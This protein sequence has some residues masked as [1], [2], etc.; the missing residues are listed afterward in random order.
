MAK[1]AGLETARGVKVNRAMQSSDP[2]IFAV[3]D[4]AEP[5]GLAM[6]G[7]WPFAANQAEVAV[8]VLL[9]GEV[10]LEA[11]ATLMRLKSEGI[12]VLSFGDLSKKSGDS[13]WTSQASGDD[14]WSV[15]LQQGKPKA[16]VFVGPP[17][18]GRVFAKLVQA[19]GSE[20][21]LHELMQSGLQA[22]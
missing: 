7:L 14:W 12:D 17:G 5:E 11:A 1:A 19:E 20:A 3:G 22:N 13:R 18:N 15:T 8:A 2:N 10:K 4:V 16:G 21:A 9:G 6:S